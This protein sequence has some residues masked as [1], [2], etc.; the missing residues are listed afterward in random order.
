MLASEA[1]VNHVNL[2]VVSASGL[3][4][5]NCFQVPVDPMHKVKVSGTVAA[6]LLKFPFLLLESIGKLTSNFSDISLKALHNL[7]L[8]VFEDGT[9]FLGH[10]VEALFN[11]VLIEA[12]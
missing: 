5:E 10:I 1:L 12:V 11:L 8:V 2:I 6:L 3:V 9:I 7:L 4:R